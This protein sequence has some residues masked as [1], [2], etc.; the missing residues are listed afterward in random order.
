M[1]DKA[2]RLDLMSHNDGVS[3]S[4]ISSLQDSGAD[5][6]FPADWQDCI[7][8]EETRAV[9]SDWSAQDFA[10]IYVRFRPHLESHA[11]RYLDDP[12]RVEEVVQDAFLY[13]MTSL[14]ELDSELG[15]LK[16][17]KWKVKMLSIDVIRLS[18]SR[19]VVDLDNHLDEHSLD[20]ELSQSVER[21]EDAAVVSLALSKLN[22]RH[23]EV[24]VK[25]IYEEKPTHEL[26]AELGLSE[27]ATRQLLLRA[28][29]SFKVALVGEA[30]VQGMTLSEIL[31]LAA[32]N[33]KRA[34]LKVSAF[35]GILGIGVGAFSQ[36]EFLSG[37]PALT[38]AA[39]IH[40][41]DAL[42]DMAPLAVPAPFV[43]SKISNDTQADDQIMLDSSTKTPTYQVASNDVPAQPQD[44][45][46]PETVL[47]SEG[48]AI[49]DEADASQLRDL[50]LLSVA[51]LG[52]ATSSQLDAAVKSESVAGE[53]Q[54]HSS[55]GFS[56]FIGLDPNAA[57]PV[58]Y[59]YLRLSAD[60]FVLTAVPQR[61]LVQQEKLLDGGTRIFIGATDMV[62]G[63]LD[64]A[65]GNL[66]YDATKL[67]RLGI[68]ISLDVDETGQVADN[69]SMDLLQ[70]G[71]R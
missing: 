55:S 56:A 66:S 4:P 24:I 63:D 11:R 62:I 35:I 36:F 54:V 15:V 44:T 3:S 14:P 57:S 26:S 33:S 13:L 59:L 51:W 32:R 48:T 46:K 17:L 39:V 49:P 29:R 70:L 65:L 34:A 19:N 7:A 42:V 30:D 53:V 69:T 71:Q 41:R 21:A 12:S 1:L 6:I 31:S 8:D 20:E 47:V 52:M 43:E 61:I 38:Q 67:L 50:Q 5:T 37:Y 2:P 18:A 40:E 25:S 10:N 22:P 45:E 68:Q 58:S 9:L 60:Q 16:F 23:R 64:G 28:K 27:N